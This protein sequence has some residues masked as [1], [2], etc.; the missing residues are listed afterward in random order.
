MNMTRVPSQSIRSM[1][2][3]LLPVLLLACND[4]PIQPLERVITAVNRQVN[5]LP[6]KTKIDFLFVIDNSNSMCQ[7][8]VNLADNFKAFSD[9]LYK[10]LGGS[11]DYHIAVTSTDMDSSP[12]RNMQPKGDLGRFLAGFDTTGPALQGM[13]QNNSCKINGNP[14]MPDNEN[15]G[16][17]LN[18]RAILKAS[19]LNPANPQ[20][21]LERKFQCMSALGNAR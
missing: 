2:V 3:V 6:A 19:E 21:D 16:P 9:F 8:Q 14:Q 20:E 18:G 7:E 17:L 4:H 11:A 12:G 5:E 10:E 1:L 15:C 13:R